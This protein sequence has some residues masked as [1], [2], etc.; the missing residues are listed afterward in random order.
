MGGLTFLPAQCDPK[1]GAGTVAWDMAHTD[2]E[3]LA[4]LTHKAKL[5]KTRMLLGLLRS[6][7]LC[8]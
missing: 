1:T 2:L 4:A 5:P 3:A 6:G 7:V 8:K